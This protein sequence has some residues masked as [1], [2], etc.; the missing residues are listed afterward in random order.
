[1]TDSSDIRF[2]TIPRRIFR[3]PDITPF[4]KLLFA[5][6][7]R[8]QGSNSHAWPSVRRIAADLGAATGTV[9][10]GIREL[11]AA[12]LVEVERGSLKGPRGEAR[13]SRYRVNVSDL[14]TLNVSD[15]ATLETPQRV[16]SC[17]GNVSDLATPTCQILAQNKDTEERQLNIDKARAQ[18]TDALFSTGEVGN[19][20]PP[21]GPKGRKR[22][23][24]RSWGDESE[25]IYAAYPR[26]AA[27]GRALPAIRKA[28]DTLAQRG[29]PNPIA[30]LLERVTTFAASPAGQAGK[31]TP[32][33]ATWFNGERYDDDPADWQ[34]GD[35]AHRRSGQRGTIKED[36]P[37]RSLT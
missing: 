12:G 18:Q 20:N 2:L 9:N 14:E 35:T 27:R 23:T 29:E 32:H 21:Q 8:R 16:N 36:I 6:L 28:F 1:M 3:R 30:F 26:K 7:S 22:P 15:P 37:V 34:R 10:R 25:R 5:Y 4:G 13:S 19:G 24:Q 11:Q 33:A 17:D 31:Y